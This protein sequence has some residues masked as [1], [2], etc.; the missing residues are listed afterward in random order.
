L[1]PYNFHILSYY[2]KFVMMVSL[3]LFYNTE[4]AQMSILFTIQFMEIVRV[5]NV[6]PFQSKR[7]NW[8]RFSLEFALLFFFLVNLIQ[9][10]L[11]KEIMTS[12]ASALGSVIVIFYGLGWAGVAACFYFN[13]AYIITGIYD[14]CVGIKVSNRAKMDYARKSYYYNKIKDYEKDNEASS[15]VLVNRWVKMGNLNNRSYGELPEINIRIEQYNIRS[16]S[17]KY[18]VEVRKITELKMKAEKNYRKSNNTTAGGKIE[19]KML[20][21]QAS[22]NRLYEIIDELYEQFQ[23]P[24][25]ERVVLK[26]FLNVN[27]KEYSVGEDILFDVHK[28]FQRVEL[29]SYD[30]E[31]SEQALPQLLERFPL[32]EQLF[33]NLS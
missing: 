24:H 10:T 32:D 14:F 6:W 8:L 4:Y 20:V 2:K 15:R 18:E 9:I 25:V 26:T 29:I 27:Q 28:M 21:S 11:L 31:K 7:R 17:G 1:R 3:P 12:S 5:W 16:V 23:S 19:R 22:N 33:S 13:F 30:N